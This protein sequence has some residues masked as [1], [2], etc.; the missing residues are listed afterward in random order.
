M[1]KVVICPSCQS[2]G[3][4]PDGAAGRPDSLPEVWTDVRRQGGDASRAPGRPSGLPGQPEA[5][6]RGAELGV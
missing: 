1:A 6:G 3:S 5:P 4:V 2:K